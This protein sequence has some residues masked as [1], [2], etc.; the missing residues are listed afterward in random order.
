MTNTKF[1]YKGNFVEEIYY[2]YTNDDNI[3][4]V[5]LQSR[6]YVS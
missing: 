3:L 2:H 5:N 6:S 1:K 4:H